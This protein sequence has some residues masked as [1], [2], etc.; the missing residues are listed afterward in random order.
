MGKLAIKR[1]DSDLFWNAQLP[2]SAAVNSYSYSRRW[3]PK[4]SYEPTLVSDKVACRRIADYVCLR[5]FRPA[6]PPME[7]VEIKV[8]F[9]VHPVDLPHMD[10]TIMLSRLSARC[11]ASLV[12]DFRSKI[13]KD[14]VELPTHAVKRLTGMGKRVLTQYC[15]DA[16]HG[17]IWSFVNETEAVTARLLDTNAKIIDLKTFSFV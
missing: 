12:L 8:S 14:S 1:V 5:E 2:N 6:L 4:L 7:V 11:P 10:S 13:L 16:R 17:A 3:L 9:S 15:P